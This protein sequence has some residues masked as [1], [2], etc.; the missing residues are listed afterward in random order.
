MSEA[1]TGADLLDYI[2]MNGLKRLDVCWLLGIT[3]WRFGEIVKKREHEPLHNPTMAILL[4]LYQQWP[5]QNPL[6]EYPKPREVFDRIHEIEPRI[7]K[8][9]FGM[10]LGCHP[11]WASARLDQA[12]YSSPAVDRLLWLLNNRL[13]TAENEDAAR[14]VVHEWLRTAIGEWQGRDDNRMDFLDG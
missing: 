4:Q 3:P 13:D 11:S 6:P 5:E 2:E 12:D 8:R 10:A 1:T 7:S 14:K 9:V